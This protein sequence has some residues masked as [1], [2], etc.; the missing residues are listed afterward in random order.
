ML[1][2][3]Y[4]NGLPDT[5]G[6]LNTTGNIFYGRIDTLTG[7]FN[8]LD[9]F[10]Y[11]VYAIDGSAAHNQSVEPFLGCNQFVIYTPPNPPGC[12]TPITTFPFYEIFET[13]PTCGTACTAV[14]GTVNGWVNETSDNADWGARLGTTPSSNTGPI[15]DHTNGV[16]KY[17][18]T[19][20]S[21]CFSKTA[22]LTTPCLD[23]TVMNAPTLEF[24]YHMYGQAMGSLHI[25][26]WYGCQWVLDIWTISG[27][28]QNNSSSPWTKA[29]VNL[30]PYKNVTKIRFRSITG[31]QLQSDIAIDDVKISDP[32]V[33]D[34][35]V[36]S[37]DKPVSPVISGNQAVKATFKNFGLANLTKVKVGW[38][39]N[40]VTQPAFNWSGIL[41]P[42]AVADS[43]QIGTYNFQSGISVIK[44]WTYNPNDT[45]DQ[46]NINDTAMS[47]VISCGNMHG[48]Y[49]IGGINPDYLTF[50]DALFALN[51]C[52]IDSHVVFNV[53]PGIYYEHLEITSIPGASF[54][55]T[56]TFQ[57]YGNDSTAAEIFYAPN[58]QQN[59][60]IIKFNSADYVTF[61][62]LTIKSNASLYGVV[63][64][65][66]G[67]ANYN[68]I[69]NNVIECAPSTSN[70]ASC[71]YSDDGNDN[72]N[73]FRNNHLKKGYNAIY[74]E[75]YSSTLGEKGNIFENNI[76]E[77]FYSNGI[78]L[79]YQD[80]VI[81]N[82]NK[83]ENGANS[84]SFCGC[85]FSY[86]DYMT[87]TKNKIH[88]HGG[89]STHYGMYFYHVD[90]SLTD[91]CLIAN[92]FVSLT[93]T[94]STGTASWHGIHFSS[95]SYIDVYYNS[96]NLKGILIGNSYAFYTSSGNSQNI[97]NNIF[98]N[99][100]GGYAAK[101]NTPNA[102][103]SSD[104]NDFYS[105]GASFVG[106]GAGNN[107]NSLTALQSV[108]GMNLH[109][110]D[111]NPP[112]T[113]DTDLHLISTILSGIAIPLV[114][115]T[116]DI[117]GDAR[118]L[119]PMI[120]ADEIELF[121]FDA[122]VKKILN[123]YVPIYESS[124]QIVK[125]RIFN[126]GND[127]LINIPIKYSVNSAPAISETYLGQLLPG[128]FVDYTFNTLLT[129]PLGNINIC[130]YT[131]L[132]Q[133]GCNNNDTMCISLKGEHICTPF[134][135]DD[136]DGNGPN[137]FI[138]SYQTKWELGIPLA[139]IINSP[140]SQPNVWTTNLNGHYSPNMNDDLY[141][142]YFDFSNVTCLVM[143]FY[144]W[145]DTYSGRGRCKI[146]YTENGGNTWNNLGKK[147]DSLG[148]NWYNTLTSWTGTNSGWTYTSFDLSK[149]NNNAT[150][151][152]F[153][154]K[155]TSDGYSKV[156]DGW[157]IDDFEITAKKIDI[158][159]GVDEIIYPDTPSV[160]G[161]TVV[162]KVAIKN[163]GKDTLYSIPLS[164]RQGLGIPVNETW[165]GV[166]LPDDTVH[167]SFSVSYIAN[168][169]FKLYSWTSLTG[170]T[171]KFND[172]TIVLCQIV[173]MDEMKK[174][175]YLQQNKPNPTNEKTIIDFTLPNSG[176]INFE[177]VDVFGRKIYSESKY[178]PTG[179]NQIEI[180]VSN[181]STGVYYYSI[182]FEKKRLVRKMVIY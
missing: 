70:M 118:A 159:A 76:I 140:H 75:G 165:S 110:E 67:G 142:P 24:Y 77:G 7:P 64:L 113:S 114:A 166:L 17:M 175:F 31:L 151:V 111:I 13:F 176:K 90:G 21:F 121:P 128:N 174:E 85:N 146:Q 139:S 2:Y 93:G 125:V 143:R 182:E 132:N 158:D 56:I 63:L 28:Q 97:T 58:N 179:K 169:S 73:V 181:Y 71:I 177:I 178:Y 41:I 92:N 160:G 138:K 133:D 120:G 163:F 153:K 9:T 87:V 27:Q 115:V 94:G 62:K 164:Y 162:V 148:V 83:I 131:A 52:G 6:M 38:S 35:G 124:Q 149:F 23:L 80:S 95:S 152:Q 14:C 60:Y 150:P 39:V 86:C 171:Y 107:I 79:R 5:L 122:G 136:F 25:D 99:T 134:Y 155:F 144:H 105:T 54:S 157:A 88:I 4:N 50:N 81:I 46:W 45:A 15:G 1:V 127:T 180:N 141:T 172:T 26:I 19:E 22:I 116:E 130:A 84:T 61:R 32:I 126:Y 135:F 137:D 57:G 108:S 156:L 117:D 103:L 42:G 119:L 37:I 74:M 55:S 34:A 66:T 10:C 72:Y 170:D 154:F 100:E 112:F 168:G 96:C 102:I 43:V 3:T 47:K 29:I 59:N 161:S 8:L 33:N 78:N 89:T 129:V 30:I 147:G 106:W 18:Y 40:G 69:E 173:G 20:A 68:I 82:N 123:P 104:Y 53:Y 91:R 49:N 51:Y 98:S 12:S 101:F 65:F 44:A 109:S 167:Y 36:L 145:Y 11:Y 16:G 48:I